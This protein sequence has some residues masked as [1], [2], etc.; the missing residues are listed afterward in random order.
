MNTGRRRG[1]APA[2]QLDSIESGVLTPGVGG[3]LT[4]STRGAP[5][6]TYEA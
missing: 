3:D 2:R 4:V 5:L 1:R 6:L